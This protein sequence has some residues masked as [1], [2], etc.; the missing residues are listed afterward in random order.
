MSET[1]LDRLRQAAPQLKRTIRLFT[2]ERRRQIAV[3][4]SIKP[5]SFDYSNVVMAV[6]GHGVIRGMTLLEQ[7]QKYA[8]EFHGKEREEAQKEAAHKKELEDQLQELKSRLCQELRTLDGAQTKFGLF[9]F[10]QQCYQP[11]VIGLLQAGERKVAWFKGAI[12]SEEVRSGKL[13]GNLVEMPKIW[14]R[15]YPPEPSC[16]D[17][18]WDLGEAYVYDNGGTQRSCVSLDNLPDFLDWLGRTLAQWWM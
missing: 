2:K 8:S 11:D 17:G 10:V 6:C 1:F 14:A 4:S 12:R 13:I 5:C 3:L 9:H 7:T 16:H 18:T 15:V